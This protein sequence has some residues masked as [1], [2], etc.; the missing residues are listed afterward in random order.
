MKLI[1]FRKEFNDDVLVAAQESQMND[2]ASLISIK[3]E[4]AGT[5]VEY[6]DKSRMIIGLTLVLYDEGEFIGPKSIHS[7]GEWI[8]PSYFSYFVN[9]H[10]KIDQDFLGHLQKRR[11]ATHALS[12]QEL[13]E[14]F[15]LIKKVFS[16]T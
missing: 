16:G 1:G 3:P 15:A 8:W 2:D 11:F 10:L 9:N 5:I 4:M 7:D 13:S 12:E 6:L 14:A